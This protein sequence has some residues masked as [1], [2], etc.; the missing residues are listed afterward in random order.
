MAALLPVV[1]IA[2]LQQIVE[3]F[4]MQKIVENP[5]V[6]L[7]MQRLRFCQKSEER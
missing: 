3:I 7:L 6:A 1:E 5:G 4:A 2:A